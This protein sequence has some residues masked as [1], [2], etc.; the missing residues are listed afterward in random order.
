MRKPSA[1]VSSSSN[2]SAP[3]GASDLELVQQALA[4]DAAACR[5][6]VRRLTPV[7]QR[8]VNG[9]LIRHHRIDRQETL[10]LT[11]DVFRLLFDNDGRV[12]RTWDPER[13]LSLENFVGLVTRREVNAILSSG[14]RSA[15][16]EKPTAPD[17]LEPQ[18]A[19][20]EAEV[21]TLSKDLLREVLKRLEQRLSTKGLA[22]FYAL[23]VQH[24]D[25]ET[26]CAEH[27][28]K[29][30][31]VYTWRARLK[32]TVATI[33]EEIASDDGLSPP[34]SRAGASG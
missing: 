31:A 30:D 33:S 25:V 24:L 29:R 34:T 28:M 10:D 18:A 22:L 20:P 14:R 4:R 2:R 17:D 11:Q 3:D 5:R 6:L 8:R 13:G 16:A 21:R 7:I 1:S 23:F 27:D 32:K 26:I 9:A 19:A 12:L 15:W